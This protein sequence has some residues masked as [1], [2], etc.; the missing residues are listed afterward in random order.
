VLGQHGV[1]HSEALSIKK[2]EK[3]GEWNGKEEKKEEEEEKN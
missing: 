3:D 1:L 2:E